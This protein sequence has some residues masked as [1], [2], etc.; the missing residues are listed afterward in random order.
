MIQLKARDHTRTPMQ[1]DATPNAG[2]CKPDVKP[3]IRVNDDFPIVNV[4]AQVDNAQ[5]VLS[6]WRRCLAFRKE[7]TDVFVYGG[8]KILDPENKDVVAYQRFSKE[9]CWI[10]LVTFT[11]KYVGWNIPED[12]KVEEWVIG[13]HPL[14]AHNKD[15]SDKVVHLRPWEG[16][17]GRC[18]TP[19][20][21]A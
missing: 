9:E 13:N 6:Y 18:S 8:F 7:H 15:V 10:T 14:E 2:F 20:P 11:A 17:I 19:I 5:S 21:P 12:I 4:T 3:W 16:V 1:W